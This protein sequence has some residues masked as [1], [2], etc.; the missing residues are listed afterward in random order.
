MKQ[1]KKNIM[2]CFLI[3]LFCTFSPAQETLLVRV[4]GYPPFYFQD[5]EGRWIGIEIEVLTA[6]ANEAG[7]KLEFI[8]LP[9]TRA[10]HYLKEGR[11]DIMLALTKTDEREEFIDYIGI[12]RFEQVGLIVRKENLNL[13][14]KNLDDLTTFDKRFGMQKDTHFPYITERLKNDAEFAKSFELV[15]DHQHNINKT[16]GR[17]I[18]GFFEEISY[19]LY[20]IET[21]R[22]YKNL[23]VHSFTLSE[24]R[25]VYIGVS[26]KTDISIRNNLR[27]AYKKLEKNGI[28]KSIWKKWNT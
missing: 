27:Q 24:P 17:R 7:Y 21:D 9:W 10:I 25:P 15:T 16:N 3:T 11:A 20:K 1:L 13:K 28:I 6:V 2:A 18:L 14:I 4:T 12:S 22:E 19:A 23:A 5:E 26:K 8:D